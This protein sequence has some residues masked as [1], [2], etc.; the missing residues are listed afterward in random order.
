MEENQLRLLVK[1]YLDKKSTEEELEVFV[2]LMKLGKLDKY[3]QEAMDNDINIECPPGFNAADPKQKTKRLTLFRWPVAAALLCALSILIY[4]A[5]DRH[6][7]NTLA[8]AGQININNLTGLITKNTLPDGSIVWLNPMAILSYPAKFGKIREVAM[9]G[10]AFFEVAK[11]HAHPFIVT[12]GKVL[13]KV[14]GTSFRIRAM[15]GDSSTQVSVLTGKVSV[16]APVQP[17]ASLT[18]T[19]NFD[20]KMNVASK[21]N[22]DNK[23][24]ADSKATSASKAD[25]NNN[26]NLNNNTNLNTRLN[27][28][29]KRSNLGEI[30]LH[31]NEEATYR[32]QSR[33]LLKAK[34]PV[35]SDLQFWRKTNLSFDDTPL[36]SIATALGKYYHVQIKLEN[37]DIAKLRLTA[38]FNDKNMADILTLICR[39]LHT[40]YTKENNTIILKTTN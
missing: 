13:T 8:K 18:S 32:P 14:W 28:N 17:E 2:S 26:V 34:I 27:A 7:A 31:P 6:R 36:D 37:K 5:T 40:S 15:S 9:R 30:I 1:R 3:I 11:D 12:S 10:E 22:S 39:S 38:D 24:N 35:T 29:S 25:L 21:P 4:Q 16:M 19:G 20:H 23:A 33:S